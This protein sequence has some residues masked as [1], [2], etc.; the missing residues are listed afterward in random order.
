MGEQLDACAFVVEPLRAR[1][2][3]RKVPSA[4]ICRHPDLARR[5]LRVEDA[6]F[7]PREDQRNDV[8]R[9]LA[10]DHV[11]VDI[12]K[13][14]LNSR[15]GNLSEPLV[16]RFFHL[17][18]IH[19][20][21][22]NSAF[23]A[24]K[25]PSFYLSW[26]N[27]ARASTSAFRS[28]HRSVR[29]PLH[30]GAP[31]SGE[32]DAQPQRS[33]DSWRSVGSVN[34]GVKVDQIIADKYRITQLIGQGGMGTVF[35]AVHTGTGGRVAI[36]LIASQDLKSEFVE[37]FQREARAAGAVDSQH[38][39]RV[40]DTGIDGGSG[41]PYMAMERMYGEDLGQVLRRTGP[42]PPD[43]SLRI[44]AQACLG[45]AKAHEVGVVHRDIKPANLFLANGD[46]GDVVVK[47]ID[48]GIAKVKL[49]QMAQAEDG[50]T[51]TGSMLGSPHYMS[52]EQAQGLKTVDQ[53]TDI[54][55][56]G[57]VLYKMLTGR[58]PHTGEALG[59][60]ILAICS[61]PATP[62]QEV[63]PWVPSDI[64]EVVHQCLQIDPAKRYQSATDLYNAMRPLVASVRVVNRESL[65]PLPPELKSQ[66]AEAMAKPAAEPHTATSLQQHSQSLDVSRIVAEQNR[67]RNTAV[68]AAVVVGSLAVAGA[69]VWA[70]Q[71]KKQHDAAAEA[72]ALELKR[73]AVIERDKKQEDKSVIIIIEPKGADVEVDGQTKMKADTGAIGFAGVVGST[74]TVK[75]SYGGRSHEE[76]VVIAAE[77]GH[78]YKVAL[79]PAAPAPSVMVVEKIVQVQAPVVKDPPKKPDA[80]INKGSSQK[81]KIGVSG[82]ME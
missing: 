8:A 30:E 9:P 42:L 14:V 54:W 51:R 24:P 36:K 27:L 15:E 78:Q 77:D 59:Q 60:V 35:E 2:V 56:L 39:V 1:F 55:S 22:P 64:A 72:K 69:I 41:M 33:V 50:L 48:F 31:E 29:L 66:V 62:I 21:P 23:P 16:D 32:S 38:I 71:V 28:A 46:S 11:N 70:V 7:A 13:R 79:P 75:V 18:R 47:L 68:M 5:S 43:V 80:I 40:L 17:V 57:V 49:D 58:T 81:T 34:S 19:R 53:R 65:S 76:T 3:V 20:V 4:R 12:A 52:P 67:S 74:H 45:L 44:L 82:S 61:Q 26:T 25:S 37:R 6:T 73:V 10:I 63:A